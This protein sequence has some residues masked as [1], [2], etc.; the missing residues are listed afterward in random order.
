MAP[1]FRQFEPATV[2]VNAERMKPH[3]RCDTP[4]PI[5]R[6]LS[7]TLF[8]RGRRGFLSSAQPPETALRQIKIARAERGP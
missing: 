7:F 1:A 6:S 2:D 3:G 8:T 4:I 5:T